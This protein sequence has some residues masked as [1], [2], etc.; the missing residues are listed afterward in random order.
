MNKNGRE[1]TKIIFCILQFIDSARYMASSLSNLVSN[2]SEGIH[3]IKC[4]FGH[5]DKKCKTC[6]IKYKYS[7][8]FLEYTNFKDDLIGCKFS[9]VI[10]VINESLMKN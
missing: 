8:R 6:G 9:I 7:E 5:D 2:L 4:E 10:K 3:R 1:V